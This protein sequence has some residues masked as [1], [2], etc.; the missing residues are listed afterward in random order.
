MNSV[1]KKLPWAASEYWLKTEIRSGRA[2]KKRTG[3]NWYTG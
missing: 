1:A 2:P 3:Q